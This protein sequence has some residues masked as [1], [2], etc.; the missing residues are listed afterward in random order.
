[1]FHTAGGSA[2]NTTFINKRFISNT[3]S[4]YHFN[5]WE[6]ANEIE[7]IFYKSLEN[8]IINNNNNNNNENINNYCIII[9]KKYYF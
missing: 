1:M 8:N 5:C 4:N 6:S 7:I 3:N 2:V 9:I